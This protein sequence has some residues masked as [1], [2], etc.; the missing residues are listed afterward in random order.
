M[1]EYGQGV[2]EGAGRVSG[3]GDPGRSVDVGASIGNLVNDSVDTLSAM[4]PGV[5]VV[6]IIVI[7]VGLLLLKRAF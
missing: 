5:L 7:F 2:G 3:G 1:F 6:G 4:P